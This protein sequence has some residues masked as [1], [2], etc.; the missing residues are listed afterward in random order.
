MT[1]LTRHQRKGISSGTPF[2]DTQLL[3]ACWAFPVSI[4]LVVITTFLLHQFHWTLLLFPLIAGVFAR[5]AWQESR[6]PFTMLEEVTSVLKRC[7]QG[8]LHHRITDTRRLGELGKLAWELNDLLDR[9]ECQLNE[10]NNCFSRAAAGQFHRRPFSRGMPGRFGASLQE[11][12]KVIQIIE[13][14]YGY[15]SRNALFSRLHELNT[16]H[17]LANLKATQADFVRISEEMDIVQ[18]I[19]R[20]NRTAA[21][22]SHQEVEHISSS[23]TD[24]SARV[25]NVTSSISELE[26]ES[27]TITAALEIISEIAD[28]TNLLALNATIEAA[29]AGEH[30]RGFAVVASEVRGLAERTKEATARIGDMLARFRSRVTA[31][32]GEAEGTRELTSRIAE[33]VTDFQGS[34]SAFADSARTTIDR[35]SYTKDRAFGSLVKVDHIIFKQNGYIA[36]GKNG[37]G[38]EAEAVLVTDTQCRLGKWYHAGYGKEHFSATRAYGELHDPHR[39]VHAEVQA[40]LE[41]AAGDWENDEALRADILRHIEASEKASDEVMRLVADMIEEQYQQTGG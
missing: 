22:N 35:I 19:A 40:A 27:K 8:E 13:D 16:N 32:T 2:F 30:G 29:R 21:E 6:R 26:Q 36:L 15:L 18:Q 11:A 28:Q 9:I 41:A 39:R 17:L 37:E 20:E 4:L 33:M 14:N 1:G 12:D 34:F 31:M 25:D 5:Y 7:C 3:I 24:I 23:L 38:D 10:L